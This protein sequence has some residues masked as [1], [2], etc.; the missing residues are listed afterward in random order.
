MRAR[1]LA[2]NDANLKLTIE[3]ALRTVGKREKV[4]FVL[5]SQPALTI[6]GARMR[7]HSYITKGG[8][9]RKRVLEKIA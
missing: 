1:E 4:S 2:P 5:R 8:T 3:I 9:G 7:A 6:G